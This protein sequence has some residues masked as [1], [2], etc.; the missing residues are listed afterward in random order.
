MSVR[1]SGVRLIDRVGEAEEISNNSAPAA[2][3]SARL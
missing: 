2:L 3:D 1:T